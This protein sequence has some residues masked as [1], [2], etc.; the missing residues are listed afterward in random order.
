MARLRFYQVA[1]S[2]RVVQH[3][4]LAQ[5]MT[6]PHWQGRKTDKVER[7]VGDDK[8]LGRV[9]EVPSDGIPDTLTKTITRSAVDCLGLGWRQS[10]RD[11][12]ASGLVAP[13][14]HNGI[15]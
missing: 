6:I 15:D 9:T 2:G 1:L 5:V 12:A 10:S 13:R 3:V 8:N 14:F 11:R 7:S 4:A